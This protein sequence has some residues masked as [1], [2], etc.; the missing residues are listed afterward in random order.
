M[1]GKGRLGKVKR[2][3]PD[4]YL[5]LEETSRVVQ[6]LVVGEA[7]ALNFVYAGCRIWE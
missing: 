2:Y 4:P 6:P 7:L 3:T 5:F 1:L